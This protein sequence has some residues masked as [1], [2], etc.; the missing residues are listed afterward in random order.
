MNS[1]NCKSR[2][3]L[4]HKARS[5]EKGTPTMLWTRRTILCA[6]ISATVSCS[7]WFCFCVHPCS[8][9]SAREPSRKPSGHAST[10]DTHNHPAPFLLPAGRWPALAQVAMAVAFMVW[11]LGAVDETVLGGGCAPVYSAPGF[12]PYPT[13]LRWLLR[14]VALLPKTKSRI[15][16]EEKFEFWRENQDLGFFDIAEFEFW[17]LE[18]RFER[19]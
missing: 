17:G 15:L 11:L 3:T 16:V 13:E 10:Y 9:K 19:N 14:A 7:T 2:F 12:D 5:S 6:I 1:L 8:F 18:M 4:A